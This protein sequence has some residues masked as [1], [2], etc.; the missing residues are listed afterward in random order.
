MALCDYKLCD[1]CGCKAFYDANL[2][3]EQSVEGYTIPENEQIKDDH[4]HPSGTKLMYLGQ[5]SVICID[6][7]KL[8]K[9]TILPIEKQQVHDLFKTGD[10]DAPD[11]IKDCNGEVTLCL[12]K[13]CGRAEDDLKVPCTIETN[14]Q[15][16]DGLYMK[17]GLLMATCRSCEKDYEFGSTPEDYDESFSYCGGSPACLP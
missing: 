3:Y 7:A 2:Q 17:N 12:C 16:P 15:L 11:A 14:A 13:V 6:C 9:T 1:V 4:G 8:Y 5:W 10:K